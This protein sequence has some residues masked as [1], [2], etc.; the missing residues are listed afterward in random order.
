MPRHL[1][2]NTRPV[3]CRSR[4]EPPPRTAMASFERTDARS[5]KKSV[6]H[7]V[8][9]VP[10]KDGRAEFY[11]PEHGATDR[12]RPAV[13]TTAQTG[14]EPMPATLVNHHYGPHDPNAPRT[15]DADIP[16][17]DNP[18]ETK[19]A[20]EGVTRRCTLPC[21]RDKRPSGLTR[22]SPRRAG[23]QVTGSI[24]IADPNGG[25]IQPERTL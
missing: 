12:K 11:H 22:R 2:R 14:L 3:F 7:P 6:Q 13:I 20:A 4:K 5:E 23:S 21:R 25:R 24:S 8:G 10:D 1:R 17:P 15:A 9:G 18:P 19:Q 16:P